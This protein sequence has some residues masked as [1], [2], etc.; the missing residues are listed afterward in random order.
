MQVHNY[1]HKYVQVHNNIQIYVQVHNYVQMYV[2]GKDAEKVYH[3]C[4]PGL[5]TTLDMKLTH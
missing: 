4:H 5:A 1:V 3:F 2:Q